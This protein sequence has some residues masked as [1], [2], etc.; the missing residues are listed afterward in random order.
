M[1]TDSFYVFYFKLFLFGGGGGKGFKMN[2][3]VLLLTGSA[4]LCG[5]PLNFPGCE[6]KN[7]TWN[8]IC[9]IRLS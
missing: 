7:R 4:L 6:A 2:F 1:A 5:G 3:S 8:L 9:G